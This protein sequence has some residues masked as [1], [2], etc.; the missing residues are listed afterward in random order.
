[1]VL[2]WSVI[3]SCWGHL[4]AIFGIA[5]VFVI[6][7]EEAGKWVSA[8]GG[9]RKPEP[10]LFIDAVPHALFLSPLLYHAWK[11][12]RN[13]AVRESLT[14]CSTKSAILQRPRL[15]D[16]LRQFGSALRRGF[17]VLLRQN[18][19]VNVYLPRACRGKYTFDSPMVQKEHFGEG[20]LVICPLAILRCADTTNARAYARAFD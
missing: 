20:I 7:G 14:L 11:Q 10:V 6:E 19:R 15:L 8:L 3:G 17:A 4:P 12:Q 5:L 2:R 13:A 18:R 9:R 16:S 1:M